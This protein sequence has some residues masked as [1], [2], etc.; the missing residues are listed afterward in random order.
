MSNQRNAREWQ[1]YSI[2]PFQKSEGMQEARYLFGK[3]RYGKAPGAAVH[4]RRRERIVAR[5]DG[6]EEILAVA[7]ASLLG[8]L[9]ANDGVL[10]R[11]L[12][13]FGRGFY[14]LLYR[15]LELG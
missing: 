14:S 5:G 10:L 15:V 9:E 3:D 8:W 11:L 7:L 12:L 4:I 1:C 6:Y 2:P 13:W